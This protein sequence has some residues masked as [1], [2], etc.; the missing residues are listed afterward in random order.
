MSSEFSN[1]IKPYIEQGKRIKVKDI[2]K[3]FKEICNKLNIKKPL[4]YRLRHTFA[5][6]HFILKTPIKLI[7]EWLGHSTIS[8]TLDIYTDYDK[9]ASYEKIKKLYNNFYYI[10]Q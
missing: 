8:L 2:G 6:N 9:T 10:T 5:S 4:L 7:Q 1:Y 3:E